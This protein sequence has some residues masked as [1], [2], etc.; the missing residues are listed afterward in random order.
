MTRRK[1]GR[2]SSEWGI[3]HLHPLYDVLTIESGNIR[4]GSRNP[5]VRIRS[6]EDAASAWEANRE[7][8]MRLC[9]C[10]GNAAL[11]AGVRLCYRA[12]TRPWA[13]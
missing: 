9:V 8:F 4:S 1:T 11:C 12:G 10:D 7:H 6:M 2:G 13:W 3:E 5:A